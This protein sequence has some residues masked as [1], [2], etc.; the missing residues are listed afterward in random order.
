M[1]VDCHKAAIVGIGFLSPIADIGGPSRVGL[2]GDEDAKAAWFMTA[3][4]G[5]SMHG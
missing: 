1:P 3:D 2:H 5:R 4:V